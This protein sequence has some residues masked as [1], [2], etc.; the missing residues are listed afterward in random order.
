MKPDGQAQG[1]KTN[2]LRQLEKAHVP[3][4]TRTYTLGLEEFSG[5]AVAQAVGLPADQVFKTL[6]ARADQHSV[7]LACIP[8]AA[9]LDLKRLAA[10]SGHKR[11]ELVHVAELQGLTGY[12]RGSV[13]PLGVKRPY[14]VFL[15]E[16]A[17]RWRQIA[18]S[19]G[20]R[21]LQ[22]LLAPGD[23]VRVTGARV[24]SLAREAGGGVAEGG[25]GA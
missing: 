5:P 23:L 17:L 24:V 7:V 22:V 14:P 13:S 15:D 25:G 11:A 4:E 2:A 10:A 12:V 16:S 9:E 1:G 20:R 21:G 3:Y 8:V 18:V 6:V 19:A